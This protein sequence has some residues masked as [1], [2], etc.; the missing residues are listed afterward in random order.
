MLAR[1]GK[2]FSRRISRDGP[3]VRL[4]GIPF[5]ERRLFRRYIHWNTR[6]SL[7]LFLSHVCSCAVIGYYRGI[8]SIEDVDVDGNEYGDNSATIRGRRD[9]ISLQMATCDGA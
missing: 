5:E 8:L 4:G 3:I 2:F 6:S 1:Y 7:S 9:R